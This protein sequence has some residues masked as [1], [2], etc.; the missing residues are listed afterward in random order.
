MLSSPFGFL[1]PLFVVRLVA[2]VAFATACS[3]S[4]EP[5]ELGEGTGPNDG[6]FVPPPTKPEDGQKNQTT[7]GSTTG[8]NTT[9]TDAP[10]ASTPAVPQPTGGAAASCAAPQCQ[11]IAGVCGCRG[12]SEGKQTIMACFGGKC[13]CNDKTLDDNGACSTTPNVDK[14]KVLFGSCGCQ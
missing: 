3:S 1:S 12:G 7:G 11:G 4:D 2:L 5:S 13:R 9:K 10:P 8:G 6:K 14:L